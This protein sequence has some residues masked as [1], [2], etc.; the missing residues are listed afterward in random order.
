[1]VNRLLE[2]CKFHRFIISSPL[3][4]IPFR[5]YGRALGAGIFLLT[6]PKQVVAN[7]EGHGKTLNSFLNKKT[8]KPY[9]FHPYRRLLRRS[10]H[11]HLPLKARRDRSAHGGNASVALSGGNKKENMFKIVKQ[12]LAFS[13]SRVASTLSAT[14]PECST[15]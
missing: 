4:G 5:L 6:G 3:I 15:S 14:V 11:R 7:N 12:N 10:D 2:F 8:N 9:F 13:F 1:M